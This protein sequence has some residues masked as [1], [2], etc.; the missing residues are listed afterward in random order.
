MA[1]E[2]GVSGVPFMIVNGKP[3]GGALLGEALAEAIKE[4]NEMK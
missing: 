1:Q 2:I 4:S 3:R